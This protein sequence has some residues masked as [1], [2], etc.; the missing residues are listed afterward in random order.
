ML[1]MGKKSDENFYIKIH[2]KSLGLAGSYEKKS[3]S[4]TIANPEFCNLNLKSKNKDLKSKNK[5]QKSKN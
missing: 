3:K 4:H 1:Q 2:L 5:D